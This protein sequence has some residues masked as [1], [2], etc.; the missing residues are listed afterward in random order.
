M[1]LLLM[2]SALMTVMMALSAVPASAANVGFTFDK[3]AVGIFDKQAIGI[4]HGGAHPFVFG[5]Q[6]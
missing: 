5:A 3:T 6:F 2:I 1:V 4:A